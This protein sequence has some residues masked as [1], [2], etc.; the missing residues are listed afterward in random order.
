[1]RMLLTSN[2]VGNERIRDTLDG[3]L[4]QPFAQS[5]VAVV[6]DAILPFAG[7]NTQ[8]LKHLGQLHSLGWKEFDL[9]SLFGG[10]H[11]VIE[12]RL[13][14]ADV[15]FCYGGSNHW[16]ANAWTATGFAPLLR[17][18]LDE[19]VYLGLSAGSMIFS[20]QHER[21]VEAFDDYEEVEMLQL[22]SVAAAV[23]LFDWAL[24]PH[25]GAPYF[26][27]QTDEW[28]AASAARLGGP[29]YFIDDDTALLVREPTEAPV[30]VSSGH[31]LHFDE[32][33]RLVDSQ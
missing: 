23:P 9:M 21:V 10:P 31:W 30:V 27:G 18:L 24:L 7:D 3:L 5:R 29:V 25:L 13:R 11:S 32:R 17:E 2:G 28:A 22:D 33:G 15:I 12:S 20:R 6:I 19:K 14:S 1:M 4:D 16:L 26:P 8:T